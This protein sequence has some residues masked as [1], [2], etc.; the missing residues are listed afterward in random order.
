MQSGRLKLLRETLT[1]R[2]PADC[3]GPKVWIEVAAGTTERAAAERLLSHAA[4]CGHCGAQLKKAVDILH[5]D[6]IPSEA[7]P[8][9]SDAFRA[10][11]VAELSRQSRVVSPRWWIPAAAA[12]IVAAIGLTFW[13]NRPNAER[14]LAQAYSAERTMEIRF[15]GASYAPVRVT[16]GPQDAS[17]RDPSLAEAELLIVRALSQNP[18]SAKWLQ[19]RSRSDLLHWQYDRAV[20]TLERL[21]ATDPANAS[22]RADLGGA[23]LLRGMHQHNATDL[24]KAVESLSSVLS[25]GNGNPDLSRLALFNRA[26]ALE[27]L[28]LW[29]GAAADWKRYL[30][31][32]ATGGWAQEAAG[33]LK[34]IEERKRAWRDGLR[35]FEL[36]PAEFVTASTRDGDLAAEPFLDRALTLW[37][38]QAFPR[39]GASNPAAVEAARRLAELLAKRHQDFWLADLLAESR[40][41]SFPTAIESLAAAIG[42]NGEGKRGRG[43]ELGK[44]AERLF[45]EAGSTAG[46]L[47]ARVERV[48]SLSRAF[49]SAECAAEG[50]EAAGRLLAHKYRW[51]YGQL[52]LERSMCAARAGSLTDAEALIENALAHIRDAGYSTLLLRGLGL[53]ENLQLLVGN[54]DGASR[55]NWEGLAIFW[56]GCHPP[57]RAHHFYSDLIQI[58]ER[59]RR[60]EL[61]YLAGKEAVPIVQQIGLVST[62]G[63]VRYRLALFA[64]L[65]GHTAEA[66]AEMQ[67]AEKVLDRIAGDSGTTTLR[68]EN[69]LLLAT[70]YLDSGH[71][72]LGQ[73]VLRQIRAADLDDSFL[74]QFLYKRAKGTAALNL[75]Q[76][77]SARQELE[78]ALDIANKALTHVRS[79]RNRADWKREVGSVYRQMVSLK[80]EHDHDPE[81]A[82]ALWER[83]RSVP[84][85]NYQEVA[86]A[87]V[88]A[89]SIRD[90]A[91]S[92]H[93]ASVLTFAELG[94]TL[95]GWLYDDRG[96]RPFQAVMKVPQIA[97]LCANLQQTAAHRSSPIAE[98]RDQSRRV[99][100]E[101]IRP[102]EAYLDPSRLLLIEPDGV[103]G[104]VP[105]EILSGADGAYLIDRFTLATSPGA[106]AEKAL[107]ALDEPVG[108]ELHAVIV[109]NPRLGA[110]LIGL[111]PPLPQSSREADLLAAVF[112][113]HT[114]L[115]GAAATLNAVLAEIPRAGVF[116]FGGHGAS[117]PDRG[118][119]LLAP[120]SGTG[121]AILDGERLEPALRACR[122]AILSACS[123]AAG[124]R[125]G[126]F[127]PDSLVQAL[128]RAGVP[129]VLATRWE[130]ED[131]VTAAVVSS[132]VTNLFMGQSAS[133]ALRA[134]VR[135]VRRDPSFEHPA[136]WAAFHVFGVAGAA[137]ERGA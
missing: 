95:A 97:A 44:E 39:S 52:Q 129:N 89:Q 92:Y 11:V 40:H 67:R 70:S 111:Y 56:K 21:A 105:F 69:Q 100:D 96:I 24:Q 62:E 82:L 55:Q 86:L 65:I 63:M 47:R 19:L 128:W 4:S 26:I 107:S 106:F 23:L 68:A 130:V 113:R 104:G 37:L 32:D 119:L 99:Y 83:F 7:A 117:Q 87:N 45:S 25:Q 81:L 8:A 36:A 109:D 58:A 35:K 124:E 112:P 88:T 125:L 54:Y 20:S 16:K 74:F 136:A 114:R 110:D 132:F 84:V 75:H 121:G 79:E 10:R 28:F 98:I 59:E 6:D 9:L 126:P 93:R 15:P 76:Y 122:L 34:Q 116:Y 103:C 3:P 91:G 120:E 135:G 2:R 72:D 31:L 53:A 22:V 101:L 133:V 134:A 13:L 78:A 115:S 131:R 5:Y 61:G 48:Y 85:R 12:I 118:G 108:R 33:R 80:L 18:D 17:P 14:L 38:P 94:D 43:Y 66:L 1:R 57:L 71:L 60:W 90:L 127:N 27:Q 46:A 50:Q 102:V 77:E 73:Q 29:D 49:R 123:T 137:K 64:G 41:P 30:Q 51:A 42:S